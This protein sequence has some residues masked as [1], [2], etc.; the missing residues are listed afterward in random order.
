MAVKTKSTKKELTVSQSSVFRKLKRFIEKNGYPP[1]SRELGD[2]LGMKAPSVHEHLCRLED[3]GYISRKKH[4]ARSIDIIHTESTDRH[5]IQGVKKLCRVPVLGRIAAGSPVF[6]QE[7]YEGEVLADSNLAAG[8]RLFALIVTGDS[9]MDADI[10]DG[11]MVIVRQQPAAESGDIVAAMLD[12]EAT[13]KRLKIT[14]SQVLLIPENPSYRPMDV[15]MR[16][17]FRIL[18]RVIG[19][20]R[21]DY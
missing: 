14:G 21:L 5:K 8:A 2:I 3:K 9:M 18:G 15:T 6:A 19:M 12:D 7:N 11:D 17:D 1:T 16:E 10:N 4:Q 13:I 20:A